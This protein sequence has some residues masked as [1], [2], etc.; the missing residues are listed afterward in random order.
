VRATVVL[1]EAQEGRAGVGRRLGVAR[2]NVCATNSASQMVV[3]ERDERRVG[4]NCDVQGAAIG[5]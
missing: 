3:A 1:P 2:R 5:S 4:H